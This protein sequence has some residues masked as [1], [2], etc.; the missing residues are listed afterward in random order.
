MS[1][2]ENSKS[3][4]SLFSSSNKTCQPEA[5]SFLSNPTV[6]LKQGVVVSHL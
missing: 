3:H 1:L 2:E 4:V 5:A 6:A